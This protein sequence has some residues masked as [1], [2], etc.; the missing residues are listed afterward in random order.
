[1]QHLHD[2]HSIARLVLVLFTVTIRVAIAS[3]IVQLQVMQLVCSVYGGM[4]V[5]VSNDD[6][7][8]PATGYTLQCPLCAGSR[9][10]EWP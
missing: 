10:S 3:P 7:S 5:L 2:A 9:A 8:S 6:G 1:M 4:K